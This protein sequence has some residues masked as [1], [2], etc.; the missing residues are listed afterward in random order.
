MTVKGISKGF[1]VGDS[2][3]RVEIDYYYRK[4]T[5]I[6]IVSLSELDARASY[7][8]FRTFLRE[9]AVVRLY[10][11]GRLLR[12]N[13][14]TFASTDAS[15]APQIHLHNHEDEEGDEF[16]GPENE[17]SQISN[18][19]N[20]HSGAYSVRHPGFTIYFPGGEFTPGFGQS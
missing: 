16:Y 6:P 8:Y 7:D 15:T 3:W 11:P 10:G 20:K 2:M 17:T 18:S 12:S 9:D 4:G 19:P 1:R 13:T 14:R 5:R